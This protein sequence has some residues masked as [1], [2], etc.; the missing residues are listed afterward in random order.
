MLLSPEEM[1]FRAF[2]DIAFDISEL[3]LSS[4]AVKT[5]TGTNPYI[6]VPYSVPRVQAHLDLI[7]A[8]PRHHMPRRPEGTPHRVTGIS[9]D[10]L[11]SG[12]RAPGR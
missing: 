3:S 10:G 1:F 8:R 4:F 5:A 7:S 2:R 11:A 9:A 6:G 12:P